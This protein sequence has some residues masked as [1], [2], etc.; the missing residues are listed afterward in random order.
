MAS[1]KITLS[2]FLLLSPL[3]TAY[4]IDPVSCGNVQANPGLTADIIDTAVQEALNIASYGAFR[5][6]SDSG[7]PPDP[8][9]IQ[10]LLGQGGSQKFAG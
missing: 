6:T 10:T 1:L 8:D 2:F 5:I 9:I 4:S 7:T 3:I